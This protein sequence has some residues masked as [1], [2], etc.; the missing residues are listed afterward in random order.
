[1]TMFEKY[2]TRKRIHVIPQNFERYLKR[3]IGVS[4]SFEKI[5]I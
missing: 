5:S 3:T 1:M 4:K 2:I